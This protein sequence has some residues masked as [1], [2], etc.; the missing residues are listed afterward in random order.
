[1]INSMF[2]RQYRNVG[3][4]IKYLYGIPTFL[5]D[6]TF[7]EKELTKYG[8][9]HTPPDSNPTGRV[10]CQEESSP[11]GSFLHL[12]WCGGNYIYLL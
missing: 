8:F 1:M 10:I 4:V 2:L 9:Y 11:M 5:Y 7:I 3:L 12:S 6:R